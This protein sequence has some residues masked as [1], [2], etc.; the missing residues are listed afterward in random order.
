MYVLQRTMNAD[1]CLRQQSEMLQWL[2]KSCLNRAMLRIEIR[3]RYFE[4][5][6]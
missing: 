6:T 3:D 1:A 2:V 4:Q 5:L